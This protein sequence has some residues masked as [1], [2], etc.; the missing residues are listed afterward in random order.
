MSFS[1]F[2][3]S[4]D[5]IWRSGLAGFILLASIG[6]GAGQGTEANRCPTIRKS[7]MSC[8][9]R[10]GVSSFIVH[11]KDAKSQRCFTFVNKNPRAEGRF[12]IA[13]SDRALAPDSVSWKT[14]EGSIPFRHKRRFAL[15]LVGVEA[16]YVRLTF[17]VDR[18]QKLAGLE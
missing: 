17:E 3:L 15:S 1:S 9:L 18:S 12:S 4:I 7:Q 16:S 8:S 10:R 5:R 13:V 2:T 14:V 11:L 6:L